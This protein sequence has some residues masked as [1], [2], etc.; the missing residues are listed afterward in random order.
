[1]GKCPEPLLEIKAGVINVISKRASYRLYLHGWSFF[2][3]LIFDIFSRLIKALFLSSDH[4][5][6]LF[7]KKKNIT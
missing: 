4:V 6:S 3:F 1:M 5:Y 2:I 7:F